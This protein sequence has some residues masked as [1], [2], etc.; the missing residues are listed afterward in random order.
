VIFARRSD[1]RRAL[2]VSALLVLVTP[3]IGGL[4]TRLRA[5]GPFWALAVS[6]SSYLFTLGFMA[7]ILTLP[8]G[9]FAPRWTLAPFLYLALVAIPNSFARGS[10]LD[11]GTW[12]IGPRTVV[13]ILPMFA[14]MTLGPLYRYWRV[15]T[16]MERQ[17]TKWA[18]L[19]IVIFVAG[20]LTTAVVSSSA[21]IEDPTRSL[22]MGETRLYCDTVQALGYSLSPLMVPVF[23]GVAIMRS[24]LWDIDVLIRRTLIYSVLTAVLGSAYLGSVLVLQ[25]LFQALAGQGQNPLVVVLSTLAI[26]ALFVPLRRRV[27]AVIDRRFYR[28]KSDAARTLAAFAEQARDETD[29]A[30]LSER[31]SGVVHE[32]MQPASVALW[33]KA[34]PR[35]QRGDKA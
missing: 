29:L 11:F 24:R 34:G 15:F 35:Q 22:A 20:A 6:V 25:G 13:F 26:A 3:G 2:F 18:V 30:R 12:P 27:Q 33:L 7:L 14:T 21:C 19:G 31:L 8:N 16:P 23:I 10:A 5:S 28:R 1:D 9:R 4:E 32:T 17:Q